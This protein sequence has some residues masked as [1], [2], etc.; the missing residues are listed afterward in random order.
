MLLIREQYSQRRQMGGS[1]EGDL[2]Y[3]SSLD[4]RSDRSLLPRLNKST[5]HINSTASEVKEMLN[6]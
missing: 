5:H 3:T 2:V 6:R 4:V 1:V